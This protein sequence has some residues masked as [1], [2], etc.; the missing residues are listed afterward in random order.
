M[1]QEI[2]RLYA[3]ESLYSHKILSMAGHDEGII[4]FGED[5]NEAGAVLLKHFNEFKRQ[6]Y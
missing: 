6:S 3:N 5:L 4:T 1:A 2:D